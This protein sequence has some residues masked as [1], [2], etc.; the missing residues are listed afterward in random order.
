MVREL[1]RLSQLDLRHLPQVDNLVLETAVS[2]LKS[3]KTRQLYIDC[4][5]TSVSP[6]KFKR[7][8]R[9]T[10]TNPSLIYTYKNLEWSNTLL[11]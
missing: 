2:V 3:D 8:F 1:T 7:R 4:D 11:E 5:G 9:G 10:Q 6:S